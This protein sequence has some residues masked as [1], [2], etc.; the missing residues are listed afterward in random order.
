MKLETVK[1]FSHAFHNFV[2]AAG[3]I[4]GFVYIYQRLETNNRQQKFILESLKRADKRSILQQVIFNKMNKTTDISTVIALS[5]RIYDMC[6]LRKIPI[7]LIC[8]MIETE[9]NWNP[10]IV[11]SLDARGLI[12]ILPATARTYC[13]AMGI[14]YSDKVLFNPIINVTIGINYIYNNHLQFMELNVETEN[15]FTFSV[16]GFFWGKESVVTLVGKKDEKMLAPN[17]AYYRRVMNAAKQYEN[18]GL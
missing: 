1:H 4:G 17:F 6:Q 3:I 7:S 14:E 15:N 8:G 9:S 10:N 11:S 2:I 13:Q 18:L 12:Q 5:D 16:S